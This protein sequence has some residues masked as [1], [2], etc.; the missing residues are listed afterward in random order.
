MVTLAAYCLATGIDMHAAGEAELARIWTKVDVIRAKQASKRDIHSPLPSSPAPESPEAQHRNSM[1]GCPQP[2]DAPNGEV[3]CC[4][5]A[6][7]DK[8]EA[9]AG[10]GAGGVDVEAL[11]S[12]MV[13]AVIITEI[14][15][16]LVWCETDC[17]GNKHVMIQHDAP[18][19]EPFAWCKFGYDYRYTDNATQRRYAE[20]MARQLGASDPIE[21][22]T[23]PIGS[24]MNKQ[25][26]ENAYAARLAFKGG[27]DQLNA[28]AA[29]VAASQV[30]H[31]ES[32]PDVR[33]WARPEEAADEEMTYWDDDNDQ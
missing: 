18:G 26:W 14:S 6:W 16:F 24:T 22:R 7:H 21:W 10:S 9:D 33:E 15:G 1:N 27:L 13:D 28:T 31:E 3:P 23:R 2:C 11:A 32:G 20:D 25:Q 8:P 29:A 30:Q 5:G 12:Q 4:C 17:T 19:A